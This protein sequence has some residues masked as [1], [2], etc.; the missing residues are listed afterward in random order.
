MRFFGIVDGAASL[1]SLQQFGNQVAHF[2]ITSDTLGIVFL[3]LEPGTKHG[4]FHVEQGL[5]LGTQVGIH[6]LF[7]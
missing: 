4:D 1:V 5:Q 7:D 3:R 2:R 6:G